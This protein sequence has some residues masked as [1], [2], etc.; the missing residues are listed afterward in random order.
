LVGES[1]ALDVPLQIPVVARKLASHDPTHD[2]FQE[3]H[4]TAELSLGHEV[5]P[6]SGAVRR[7]RPCPV[8]WEPPLDDVHA[9]ALGP[10]ELGE[11]GHLLELPAQRRLEALPEAGAKTRGSFRELLRRGVSRLPIGEV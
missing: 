4:H 8:D 2:R 3:T 7:E 11:F 5:H 6:R 1:A 10:D 9:Q